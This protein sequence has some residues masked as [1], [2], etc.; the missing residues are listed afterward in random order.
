MSI[1]PRMTVLSQR[2]MR[3]L[4][5]EEVAQPPRIPRASK[6]RHDF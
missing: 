1:E 2:D 5:V 6:Q 4:T 3:R